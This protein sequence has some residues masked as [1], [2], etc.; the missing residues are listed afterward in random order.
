MYK[1][2][3][4]YTLKGAQERSRKAA[5]LSNIVEGGEMERQK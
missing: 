3:T 5:G 2:C 4:I 1:L